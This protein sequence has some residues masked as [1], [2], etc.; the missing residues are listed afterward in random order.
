[1]VVLTTSSRP[2]VL[3]AA[4]DGKHPPRRRTARAG[5]T[6]GSRAGH[7]GL[8]PPSLDDLQRTH[9]GRGSVQV[10]DACDPRPHARS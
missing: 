7:E 3:R 9:D 8:R 6:D 4:E 2:I 10:D 1:M 5:A